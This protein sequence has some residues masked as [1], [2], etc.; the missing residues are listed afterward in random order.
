MELLKITDPVKINYEKLR[1]FVC[2]NSREFQV[3]I[4][5]NSD[6]DYYMQ[7]F[8]FFLYEVEGEYIGLVTFK[9][10]I[11]GI[12]V[13]DLIIAN[14]IGTSKNKLVWDALL[15]EMNSY[16]C[17]MFT[18]YK[19]LFRFYEK[20]LKAVYHD[21]IFFYINAKYIGSNRDQI[22]YKLVKRNEG[23]YICVQNNEI[24]EYYELL[25]GR[26]VGLKKENVDIFVFLKPSRNKLY[27]HIR[28]ELKDLKAV[29]AGKT[30]KILY[31]GDENKE[32][33]IPVSKEDLYGENQILY[34]IVLCET[35]GEQ[36]EFYPTINIDECIK[37]I[38]YNPEYLN[39]YTVQHC[40]DVTIIS[41]EVANGFKQ[42]TIHNLIA[43]QLDFQVVKEY[44][45]IEKIILDGEELQHAEVQSKWDIKGLCIPCITLKYDNS[46][47]ALDKEWRILR[48]ND[49]YNAMKT[50]LA[51]IEINCSICR[52]EESVRY[53]FV[54]FNYR[55]DLVEIE[56]IIYYKEKCREKCSKL[57]RRIYPETFVT[58]NFD[59]K[60]G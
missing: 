44:P 47:V 42:R 58:L 48:N 9:T 43:S 16:S 53:D 22:E 36:I 24:E 15:V 39:K 28:S 38:N 56:I 59:I 13:N 31:S 4:A 40:K 26:L 29:S 17:I 25:F 23:E 30:G 49:N 57:T 11:S 7:Q 34:M 14:G 50:V 8:K 60:I 21:G 55:I 35:N 1:F 33:I 41:Y 45:I 37:S 19:K 10:T 5:G 51:N 32:I 3:E 27:L 52:E 6:L 18:T 20:K 12:Y 2:Y 46:S 54:V